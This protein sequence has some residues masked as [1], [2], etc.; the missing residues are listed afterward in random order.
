MG[1]KK[2][3]STI[4][5]KKWDKK[6]SQWERSEKKIANCVGGMWR[7]RVAACAITT[8]YETFFYSI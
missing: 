1:R 2:Y 4:L 7:Q 5:R 6:K 8:K 3:S